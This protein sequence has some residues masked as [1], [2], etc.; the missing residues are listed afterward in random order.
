MSSIKNLVHVAIVETE[1][2]RDT[3]GDNK[4]VIHACPILSDS[5]TMCLFLQ[6]K[7]VVSTLGDE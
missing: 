1:K 7:L 3:A 5:Q 2:N 4:K 6:E